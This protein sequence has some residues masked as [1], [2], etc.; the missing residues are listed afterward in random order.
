MWSGDN[1]NSV[2]R[3]LPCCLSKGTVKRHFLD[4]YVIVSWR[5]GNFGNTL[6]TRVNFYLKMFKIECRCQNCRK[7]LE[8]VCQFWDNIL[9]NGYVKFSLLRGEYLS[10][11][12]N[13]LTNRHNILHITNSDFFK[14]NITRG[15][16]QVW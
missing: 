16:K 4:S 5:V 2:W 1:L 11:A 15:D 14:L 9:W 8:K 12:A 13:M 7:K 10:S 3:R 6:A